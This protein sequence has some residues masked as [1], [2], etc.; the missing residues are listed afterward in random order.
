MELR[1][2]RYFVAVAEQLSFSRAAQILHVSQSSISEQIADL[3]AEI[4]VRLLDRSAR[5]TALTVPGQTFLLRAHRILEEAR[6]AI[7]ET[8]RVEKG[9]VG[10][11]RMGFFGGGL[12]DGFPEL[13]RSFRKRY[14]RVELSLIE[15][16]STDQWPALVDGRLD[17]GFTRVPEPQFRHKLRW[18]LIQNDPIVA[19]LPN[20]HP[21]AHKSQ[22]DLK[23]LAKERFVLTSRNVSPPVHDKVFEL[24]ANAGFVPEVSS[25][26]TVWSSV[27]LLVRSG[28]GVALLPANQQQY[29]ASDVSF[30]PLRSRNASVG[31]CITWPVHRGDHEIV[32]ALRELAREYT[33]GG[34]RL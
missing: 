19:V 9:E 33:R 26:S 30:V 5:K 15:L 27:I 3:E 13:I 17:I 32:R 12:G 10:T 25:V 6:N 1:H 20:N 18:D 23:D 28:E 2:L 16:N 22:I 31:M 4:G 34:A 29:S 14:P 7:L 11:L 21:A 8:Q 24:C